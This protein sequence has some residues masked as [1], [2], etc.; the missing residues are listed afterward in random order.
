MSF[1]PFQFYSFHA[2]T[3]L[4]VKGNALNIRPTF[5]A[6]KSLSFSNISPSIR[7]S[8]VQLGVLRT[9]Y[10]YVVVAGIV[11]LFAFY[12]FTF[13]FCVFKIL[14]AQ[15]SPFSKCAFNLAAVFK[16]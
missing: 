4:W 15:K 9:T 11:V 5:M 2:F 10:A 8:S 14:Y 6:V 3:V 12:V 1:Y 7:L 16:G 13:G